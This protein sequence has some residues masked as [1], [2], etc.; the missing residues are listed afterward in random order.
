ME[1]TSNM[2]EERVREVKPGP[3]GRGMRGQPHPKVK[4]PG[5]VFRRIMGYVMKYYKIQM[6]LVIVCIFVSV[7]ANVQ[8]TMFT[9]TL[10]DSYIT[11]LKEQHEIGRASCRERV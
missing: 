11:P 8:G 10:I 3:G 1:E 5:K 4:N 7:I 6:I 2:E 9:K